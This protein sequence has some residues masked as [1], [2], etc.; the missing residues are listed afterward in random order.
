MYI[1]SAYKNF[2][3]IVNSLPKRIKLISFNVIISGPNIALRP[4]ITNLRK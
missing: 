2:Y 1:N 4:Y 3:N